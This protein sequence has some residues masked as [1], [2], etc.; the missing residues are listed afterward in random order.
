MEFNTN[1]V[2]PKRRVKVYPEPVNR[3]RAKKP[4]VRTG[5]RTC[6]VRRV[7]CD[8]QKP[9]CK[10][11]LAFGVTCDGYVNPTP[12]S[13]IRPIQSKGSLDSPLP[14]LHPTPEYILSIL[15]MPARALC[16]D[17]TSHQ[18]FQYFLSSTLA[19]LSGTSKEPFFHRVLPQAC[20]NEP[21]LL[22]LTVSL[23]A[24]SKAKSSPTPLATTHHDFA[25]VNYSKALRKIQ[26]AI[27][28]RREP[29]ATR[30]ALISS[31][32][33]FCFES[34]HGDRGLAVLHMEAALKLMKKRLQTWKAT[35]SQV[36]KSSSVPNMEYDLLSAFVRVDNVLMSR[37]DGT[38]E[39]CRQQ[40]KSLLEIKY[41]EEEV[42]M[43]T[44]FK[45][46]GEARNYMEHFQYQ[47]MPR[48]KSLAGEF[49][50]SDKNQQIPSDVS[51]SSQTYPPKIPNG[52]IRKVNNAAI[53]DQLITRLNAWH[54]AFAPL[55]ESADE[56][57]LPAA[58]TMKA[59]ALATDLA[60][61]RGCEAV[62]TE[63]GIPKNS[64][65]KEAIDIVELCRAVVNHA[66]FYK[67]FVFD[68]GIVPSL[69]IVLFSCENIKVRR[70]IVDVLKKAEGR[71]EM[72]W[73]ANRALITWISI[74]DFSI[75]C[76]MPPCN[77]IF[78]RGHKLI[79]SVEARNSFI[80]YLGGLKKLC[81]YT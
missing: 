76:C 17:P 41:R 61:R 43:P 67:G 60:V 66:S 80:L 77:S 69:F 28:S 42:N 51:L 22:S 21:A 16:S 6:K 36:D 70:Q 40:R 75:T 57:A 27:K 81:D 56:K 7:K 33:I 9:H 3:K 13:T 2:Q 37:M 19:D 48:L 32:I 38:R 45:D 15:A 35:Y 79:G 49:M 10:K 44:R 24:I 68:C 50:Y 74:L 64:F 55:F 34:V 63:S 62:N 73:E 47:A 1:E 39:Q 58:M 18:Y 65:I 59:L 20:V 23:G 46:I 25:I 72:V 31:L 26:E 71:S 29:D 8:E 52:G 30:I 12:A 14:L 4:K 78:L 54:R 5:C 11:C 53:R